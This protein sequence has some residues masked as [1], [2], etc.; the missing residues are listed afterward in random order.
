MHRNDKLHMEQRVK[1]GRLLKDRYQLNRLFKTGGMSAVFSAK[2]LI[3][4]ELVIVKKTRAEEIALLS[5]LNHPGIVKYLDHFSVKSPENSSEESEFYLVEEY[6]RGE[7]LFTHIMKH[8]TMETASALSVGRQLCAVLGY[9]Q[10]QKP[11]FADLKPEH[12]PAEERGSLLRDCQR[13][14]SRKTDDELRYNRN[15][16]PEQ[17]EG[18]MAQSD[19]RSISM[20]WGKYFLLTGNDPKNK[21]TKAGSCFVTVFSSVLNENLAAIILKVLKTIR[22]AIKAQKSCPLQYDR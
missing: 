8:G 5:G 14:V 9:L 1:I 19:V 7:N 10:A 20:A 4:G 2:D 15:A 13:I 18:S 21:K 12:Y 16:A 3:T 6:I 17:Y 11:R 22:T